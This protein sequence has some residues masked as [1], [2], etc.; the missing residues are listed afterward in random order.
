[1][2]RKILIKLFPKIGLQ[3]IYHKSYGKFANIRNPKDLYEK[4]IWLNFNNPDKRRTLLADKVLVRDHLKKKGF[5]N[6][7][8]EIYGIYNNPDEI[9]FGELPA[10]YMLKCNHGA[11]YNIHC[12]N[13]DET[14]RKNIKDQLRKWIREDYSLLYAELHYRNIKRKIIC[15]KYIGRDIKDYKVYCFNGE[16]TY[17]MVCTNRG[18]G[19]PDY[20]FYTF[21]WE[22]LDLLYYHYPNP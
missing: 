19:H 22:Y 14:M 9:K 13:P 5:G 18:N 11:N 6:Y 15:E 12:S 17:V 3:L 1:M 21:D 10:E 7:L 16:P 8:N 2:T 20:F 4:L